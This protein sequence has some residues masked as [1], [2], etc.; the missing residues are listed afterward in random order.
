MNI[1]RLSAFLLGSLCCTGFYCE[2][3]KGSDWDPGPIDPGEPAVEDPVTGD[4][5]FDWVPMIDLP[6][7]RGV[8]FAGTHGGS[9]IDDVE[10]IAP[11]LGYGPT[12]DPATYEG[13]VQFA[14]ESTYAVE[15]ANADTMCSNGD[16]SAELWRAVFPPATGYLCG[17]YTQSTV[18]YVA[19]ASGGRLYNLS[20]DGVQC[21]L[22]N[23]YGGYYASMSYD[24]LET[25]PT[26]CTPGSATFELV[27]LGASSG[28]GDAAAL[29]VTPIAEGNARF[30]ERAWLRRIEVED[31]GTAQNLHVAR[32]HDHL[33]FAGDV[34]SNGRVLT[35]PQSVM[36]LPVGQAPM[37]TMFGIAGATLGPSTTLPRV[38]LSWSCPAGNVGQYATPIDDPGFVASPLAELGYGHRVVIWSDWQGDMLRVAPEGRFVDHQVVRLHKTSQTSATFTVRLDAYDALLAG[39]ITKSAGNLVLSNAT[40]TI[41]DET[42]PVADT[43]FTPLGA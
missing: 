26:A 25:A 37:S 29:W 1:P 31:W 35:G 8:C 9:G 27:A 24:Q 10:V 33:G 38:R 5:S 23:D 41:A 34:V 15:A 32:L 17:D 20:A 6:S 7:I 3:P 18:N 2:V 16:G 22:A 36:D 39:R 11:C 4:C 21:P 14:D 12:S 19:I 40:L 13:V 43:V 28:I 42:V 30:P